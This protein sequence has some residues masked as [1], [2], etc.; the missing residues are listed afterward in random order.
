MSGVPGTGKTATV[1]EVIGS[2]QRA[3]PGRAFE[4]VELNGM[5]L[6]DPSQ[7]YSVLWRHLSGGRTVGSAAALAHLKA[8]FR[9]AP[10]P[11]VVLLDELDAL[12]QKKHSILYHF[13]EWTGLPAAQLSIVSVANTMD[14]PERLVSNRI[15]SR[16]G[17]NRINFLP[18]HFAQLEA[19]ILHRLAPYKDWFHKDGLEI[20]ARKVSAVSGDARRAISLANRA[21][22]HI[23]SQARMAGE[24]QPKPASITMQVMNRVLESAFTGS[25]VHALRHCSEL[26][27]LLL[28]AVAHVW[29]L[30]LNAWDTSFH[31]I[32]SLFW[33]KCR[34]RNLGWEPSMRLVKGAVW[35]VVEM[36]LVRLEPAH[37]LTADT[38]VVALFTEEDLMIA[39]SPR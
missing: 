9:K 8:Y 25:P 32:C 38:R 23:A 17:L 13:F 34:L 39:S 35:A 15:A 14:L 12:L 24:A 6:S 19:I 33:Q 3:R 18:Y 21:V 1:K 30:Q 2:L 31:G 7:V 26:Q 22:D 20:C 5:K 28:E 16:M 29:K 27:R 10:C 36:G 11:T 4:F 37:S